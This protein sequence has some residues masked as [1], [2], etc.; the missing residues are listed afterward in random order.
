MRSIAVILHLIFFVNCNRDLASAFKFKADDCENLEARLNSKC[1]PV[2]S[3]EHFCNK[4]NKEFKF[5]IFLDDISGIWKPDKTNYS[6]VRVNKD[7]SFDFLFP[8]KEGIFFQNEDNTEDFIL[9][10]SITATGI[11]KLS[12]LDGFL[13]LNKEKIHHIDCKTETDY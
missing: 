1:I 6:Y 4:F 13:F 3:K 2:S 5:I 8:S 12:T 10:N 11:R 9:Q 7:G